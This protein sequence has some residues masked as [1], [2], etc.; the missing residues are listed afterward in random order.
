MRNPYALFFLAQ[1]LPAHNLGF[2]SFRSF[3]HTQD[4]AL[5]ESLPKLF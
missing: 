2:A 4:P 1:D 5:R 3:T